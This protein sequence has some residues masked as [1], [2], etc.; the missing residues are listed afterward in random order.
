MVILEILDKE[1]D[2]GS[3]SGRASP[4]NSTGRSTVNV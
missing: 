3:C 1:S 4:I 2:F